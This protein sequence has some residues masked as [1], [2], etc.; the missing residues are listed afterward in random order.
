MR[1]LIE[2]ITEEQTVFN[3]EAQRLIGELQ[4]RYVELQYN[5]DELRDSLFDY[6]K[7]SDFRNNIDTL[8]QRLN[9]IDSMRVQNYDKLE[10]R[11]EDVEQ[12]VAQN[13]QEE[14]VIIKSII[15]DLYAHLD[16]SELQVL[17]IL[18]GMSKTDETK[19]S[20]ALPTAISHDVREG[21]SRY[22]AIDYFDFENHF[23]GVRHNIKAA[24]SVYVPYFEGKRNIVDLGC[25]RGEFLELMKEKNIKCI[26]VDIYDDFIMYC[27]MKGFNAVQKDVIKYLLELEDETVGGIFSAHLIEHLDTPQLVALCKRAYEV[28]EPG[29]CLILETPNPTCITTF[30]STFYCDPSHV[31]PVH[32]FTLEYLLKQ[33]GFTCLKTVYTEYSNLKYRLP[34]LSSEHI[35][36]L[37]QFNSGI[38]RLSDMLFGSLDYAIIAEKQI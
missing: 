9:D 24:Q 35:Q 6:T 30:T 12:Q 34:L 37:E 2:P 22:E 3:A 7:Y 15:N 16:R 26:G 32:P 19:E 33:A 10:N 21:I 20:L 4:E 8:I 14:K 38:N 13:L 1:F 29:G 18:K 5:C 17:K 23:R 28:L 27:R 25:G 11:F 36:N 31:K